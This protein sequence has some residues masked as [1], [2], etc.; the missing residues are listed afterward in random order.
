MLWEMPFPGVRALVTTLYLNVYNESNKRQN[1][2]GKDTPR[3]T[4]MLQWFLDK[5]TKSSYI[6]SKEIQ[7]IHK[8]SRKPSNIGQGAQKTKKKEQIINKN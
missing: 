4:K 3:S 8:S 5:P 1:K 2:L 6:G 7:I